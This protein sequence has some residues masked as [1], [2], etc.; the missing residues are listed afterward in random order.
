MSSNKGKRKDKVGQKSTTPPFFQNNKL[1][2]V[3]IALFCFLL[4]FNTLSYDYCGDDTILIKENKLVNHGLDHAA[5]LI[6]KG[7]FYGYNQQ[8]YGAYRPLTM[9]SFAM[10]V[11]MFGL[12]PFMGHFINILL[13]IICG[14]LLHRMLLQFFPSKHL[15]AL[16]VTLLFLSHPVHS[17]V[18][19]NIKS[20][21][22][23]FAFLFSFLIPASLFI[24]HDRRDIKLYVTGLFSF[25]I[26]LFAKESAV[27]MLIP[28][29]FSLWFFGRKNSR[30]ISLF[31]L[32]PTLLLTGVYLFIRNIFLDAP[33]E[34]QLSITNTLFHT[35]S[36]TE[37]VGT[38]LFI[39]LKNLEKLIFPLHLS[40]DYSYNQIPVTGLFSTPAL[41]AL[42]IF[43]SAAAYA[44][45]KMKS[46]T[47]TSYF[48]IF[49]G[50]S[51][52][53]YTHLLVMLAPN[54][55][56]RFLFIPALP[57]CALLILLLESGIEKTKQIRNKTAYLVIPVLAV[58]VLFSA[59]TIARNPV[60]KNNEAMFRSGIKDS[61]DSYYVYQTL[62]QY[63]SAKA[64]SS[65]NSVE[66]KALY[67]EAES[68][69][70]EGNIISPEVQDNWYLQGRCAYLAGDFNK[71]EY[72]YMQSIIRFDKPKKE[73]IYNLAVLY[74]EEKKYDDAVKWLNK[75]NE[76]E[77]NFMNSYS[78]L[79]EIY[80]YKNDFSRAQEAL[81]KSLKENPNQENVLNNLGVSYFSMRDYSKAEEFFSQ[82]VSL[83][84][85]S[86]NGLKNLAA[87]Y[88]SEN[89][90]DAA[91]RC[92]EI[93]IRCYPDNPIGY[94]NIISMYSLKGDKERMREYQ[95]KLNKL[96]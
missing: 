60:W 54:M 91:I 82:S 21:D 79:G 15:I 18:V 17:E 44:V 38:I 25:F 4:Y 93:L 72:A 62:G 26:G 14:I 76:L 13:Y 81:M 22:E 64:D 78:L 58:T 2:T 84:P 75:V 10:E 45:V 73:A 39:Q 48:I 34:E 56:D 66:K 3:L 8:N 92:C 50:A 16:L 69:L 61:P 71:A 28:A 24:K 31:Y 9:L 59:R 20:R 85:C 96:H 90:L 27:T 68:I 19:A 37:K 36:F 51:V 95:N 46:R 35:H 32:L 77:D 43:G 47:P 49:Y 67:T 33:P 6:T 94:Q 57:V 83:F 70:E 86:F 23:I 1:I 89:K 40:W 30:E 55:A 88:Q 53:L 41:F 29:V 65:D 12:N 52:L 80:L 11:Q 87:T 74:K 7:T 63:L 5:Q 42:V